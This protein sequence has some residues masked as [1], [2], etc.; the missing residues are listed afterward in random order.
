[1]NSQKG[2]T[3]TALV[4]YVGVSTIVISIMAVISSFFFEN[5]D[6][7]KKQENY[8]SEFNKFNM[9]FINDVKQNKTAVVEENKITFED[10]TVYQY[11]QSQKTILR[12]NTKIASNVTSLTF[13]FQEYEATENTTKNI[14]TVNISIGEN[15]SESIEYVLKYW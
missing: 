13:N 15:F 10:G 3:L 5:V 12:N 7:I 8:A 2:I 4:I 9:F 14:I 6:G 11:R 1:M